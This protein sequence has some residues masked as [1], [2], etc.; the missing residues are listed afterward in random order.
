MIKKKIFYEK[1][2]PQARF[3]MEKM[4]R[5]QDLSNKNETQAGFF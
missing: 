5:R 2:A 3:L 1:N 4:R